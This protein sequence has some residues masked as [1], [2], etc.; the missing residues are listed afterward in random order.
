MSEA[1][2]PRNTN[3]VATPVMNV[4]AGDRRGTLSG[5]RVNHL[6]HAG[7]LE[8]SEVGE[9]SLFPQ[10]WRENSKAAARARWGKHQ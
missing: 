2:L 5:E 4:E 9:E 8:G 10:L 3:Q 1:G 7:G 6:A